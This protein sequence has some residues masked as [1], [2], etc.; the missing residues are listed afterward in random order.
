MQTT[1]NKKIVWLIN[2]VS[3]Q[4]MLALFNALWNYLAVREM[5]QVPLNII[6]VFS[7]VVGILLTITALGLINEIVRLSRKEQELEINRAVMAKDKELIQVLSTHRHDFQNHLQVIMGLVQLGRN[8]GAV[9]YIKEVTKILRQEASTALRIKNLE[10]AALFSIK[11]IEAEEKQIQLQLEMHSD[12]V[13]L[14]IPATDISSILGNLLEN[15]F[16]AVGTVAETEHRVVSVSF[17]EDQHH[18]II[19]VLNKRPLIPKEIQSKIF[20]K[21]FSTK[22]MSGSGLGLAIVKELTEKHGGSVQLVSDAETGTLFT[23]RFPK[24]Y[25]NLP[26]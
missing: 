25:D 16:D 22:G 12:L 26:A 8:D 5:I 15:A 21:G 6:T 11:K 13:G 1:K 18:F 3:L 2:V 17:A 7:L 10:V 20:Q 4:A 23:L 19:S 14:V 24:A 9:N